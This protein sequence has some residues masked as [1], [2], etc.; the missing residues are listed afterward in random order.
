VVEK[1]GNLLEDVFCDLIAVGVSFHNDGDF[2]VWTFERLL[3]VVP[4][5][6]E[7]VGSEWDCLVFEVFVTRKPFASEEKLV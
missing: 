1:R 4:T 6:N 2:A 5:G 7:E 3:S